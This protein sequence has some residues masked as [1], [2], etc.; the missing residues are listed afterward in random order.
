MSKDAVGIIGTGNVGVAAAYALFQRQIASSLV[1]VD[2]DRRRAEG[3]AMDLMHGQALVGRVT[4]RAGDYADLAGCQVVVICAGVG[5]KPGESRLDLLNR[6][7]AVFRQIAAELDRYAPEAVLVVAT[8]PVDILTAVMQRLSARPH[9]LVVGT[10]TMLDTSRFRALLGEH[11][12][13][14]PRSVHAYILGEHGD[15][16]VPIWSSAT[17][18]GLP[19]VPNEINGRVFEAA[20]LQ[21]LFERVRSAAYDIIA[22]KGY[23]NTAIGLVIA[24][25]VRVILED[26]KS[27]LAVSVDPGGL[28]G[29]SDICLSIPCIV[30]AGGVECRVPPALSG[31]E[32]EGLAASAALLRTSLSGMSIGH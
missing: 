32:R 11:Y 29:L 20:A 30:G 14:N 1:L 25:L 24:Y 22:R 19:I 26:Q 23:T 9:R 15:S 7:A 27:V 16:E 18:G 4:V 12:G 10:G 17:I 2:L 31:E 21:R 3:E 6:N 8:N 28:H 5:Q 13:V